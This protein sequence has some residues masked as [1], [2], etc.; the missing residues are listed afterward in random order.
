MIISTEV[1]EASF[2]DALEMFE[3]Y[4]TREEYQRTGVS[5]LAE[6]ESSLPKEP[7][8][9][10][11]TKLIKLFGKHVD[12]FVYPDER[13]GAPNCIT[14]EQNF[15]KV[16]RKVTTLEQARLVLENGRRMFW[17]DSN[18]NKVADIWMVNKEA[19]FKGNK[20][21]KKILDEMFECA[22]KNRE[23]YLSDR[24]LKEYDN[25][26]KRLDKRYKRF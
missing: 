23:P 13:D 11:V 15:L 17:S 1:H 21:V 22:A 6:L 9:A 12:D 14:Y 26:W 3:K 24:W 18:I 25:D 20:E 10:S 8:E 5:T 2:Y 4:G 19:P 16:A 7:T